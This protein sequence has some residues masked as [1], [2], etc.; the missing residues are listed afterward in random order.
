[1]TPQQFAKALEAAVLVERERCAKKIFC[2]KDEAVAIYRR[3]EE[4]FVSSPYGPV[5]DQ[6]VK[7]LLQLLSRADA[8]E[9]EI[10]AG[11]KALRD[12]M[13]AKKRTPWDN[14][15]NFRKSK[16][17]DYAAVVLTAVAQATSKHGDPSVRG[18]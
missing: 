2:Q 1:M 18:S 3:W 8:T 6:A 7:Q 4:R 10:D 14:L 15:P 17:R 12:R 5:S 9:T 11:A 13:A 16:W